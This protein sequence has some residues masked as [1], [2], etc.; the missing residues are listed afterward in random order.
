MT[1]AP[2]IVWSD[3]FSLGIPE[4]DADHRKLV[5]FINRLNEIAAGADST[6]AFY[7]EVG[8]L[9]AHLRAHFGREEAMLHKA[10]PPAE[11]QA[12][13]AHHQETEAFFGRLLQGGERDI[14]Q[15]TVLRYL[16]HWL[17]DHVLVGDN[18]AREKLIEAGHIPRDAIDRP[19]RMSRLR[20]GSRIWMMA[21][22]PL[23][24][25]LL[26]AAQLGLREYR[27]A[28]SLDHVA[29][30][31]RSAAIFGDVVHAL[32]K[33]RG[34]S[35]GFLNSKGAQFAADVRQFRQESDAAM[36]RLEAALGDGAALGLAAEV[37]AIRSAATGLGALRGRVDAFGIPVAEEVAAYTKAIDDILAGVDDMA[38]LSPDEDTAREMSA[39]AIFLHGKD[40][41]GIERAR[42]AAG[43]GAGKFTPA[44][45]QGFVGVGA[46]QDAYFAIA[47]DTASGRNR[48]ALDAAFSG[49][50]ETEVARLRK[51]AAGGMESGDFAGV[52]GTAWFDAATRRI[53][54]LKATENTLAANLAADA[55]AK[56][57]AARQTA[58]LATGGMAALLLAVG[59]LVAAIIASITRPMED[60]RTA[61][62]K[63]SAG[64]ITVPVRGQ[65]RHDEIGLIARAVHAFRQNLVRN[66][67]SEAGNAVDVTVE[68]RRAQTRAAITQTFRGDIESFLTTL[69]QAAQALQ[70]AANSMEFSTGQ[71]HRQA[72]QVATAAEG[73]AQSV[74]AVAAAAE[75]LSA[76]IGEI[77][78]Q[79]T[80]SAEVSRNVADSSETAQGAMEALSTSAV[81]IGDI[82]GII[83]DIASQTN[84][85][86]LNATIEAAR[87]GDAGKGFAVVAGEVKTLA[88][89]TAKA[90][91]E[92]E[93]QVGAVQAATGQVVSAIDVVSRN[94]RE[95]SEIAGSIA[96]AIEEQRA[97]TE[98]ISNSVVNA[99]GGT[100]NVT[101]NIAGVADANDRIGE[102]S[103][104]VSS[105]AEQMAE[106][107][108]TLRRQVE[109]YLRD[110]ATA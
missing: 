33:E 24:L 2:L 11:A 40:L 83:T 7:A 81:K 77:A 67:F 100:R 69:T 95:M 76:S 29:E 32:Q 1:T 48:E 105:A 19:P 107:T 85:L 74:D 93:A 37:A 71:S 86:A 63:L 38:A 12:H 16:Q 92:I 96:G 21:A 14:P 108:N 34:A 49:T 36:R 65:T 58:Y 25:L 52:T 54:V 106:H 5:D 41:A 64:D 46:A 73:A 101:S 109:S 20:I 43:F 79:V 99:A 44:L 39:F 61:I 88:G 23:L 56:A 15:E 30:L 97:A 82:I 94:V 42:G 17:L 102:M 103:K 80:R 10:L 78:R 60:L 27:N 45:F 31:S 6:E 91:E 4:L 9:H 26:A 72:Q 57:A 51:I 66:G 59:A 98:E 68:A 110:V 70:E 75:E 89:Q 28:D 53:D 90:T 55:S 50:A 104:T 22:A 13:I 47:R 35:A 3:A 8:N 18:Q 87:A 62:A 84:L